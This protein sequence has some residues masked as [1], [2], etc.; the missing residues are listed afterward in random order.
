MSEV[1]SRDELLD[2][3]I[4]MGFA[5]NDCLAAIVACGLD[6]DKAISW[7]VDQPPK[8]RSTVHAP[9]EVKKVAV[10]APQPLVQP[11]VS[12][13]PAAFEDP[14]AKAQKEKDR[15]EQERRIN[16]DWNANKAPTSAVDAKKPDAE[17]QI[18]QRN[19]QQHQIQSVF[20][21]T[22]PVVVPSSQAQ[23]TANA[24]T[25]QT[26]PALAP[27]VQDINFPIPLLTPEN[28]PGLDFNPRHIGGSI[29]EP[30]LH[31]SQANAN[32]LMMGLP[33]LPIQQ[34]TPPVAVRGTSGP[35]RTRTAGVAPSPSDLFSTQQKPVPPAPGLF[36]PHASTSGII[37]PSGLRRDSSHGLSGEFSSSDSLSSPSKGNQYVDGAVHLSAVARPFVPKFSTSPAAPAPLSSSMAPEP[38]SLPLLPTLADPIDNIGWDPMKIVNDPVLPS[39]FL[40]STLG[41]GL[42]GSG[43]GSGGL[44]S[45]WQAPP[46]FGLFGSGTGGSE[47]ADIDMGINI[48]LNMLGLDMDSDLGGLGRSDKIGGTSLLERIGG[49]SSGLGGFNNP[50][51][52]RFLSSLSNDPGYVGS[53][54][55]PLGH[56]SGSGL[57]DSSYFANSK[58]PPFPPENK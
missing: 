43:L 2:H 50:P 18:K 38:A 17:K 15:K 10:P 4:A 21:A 47:S 14:Q 19:H 25:V 24:P 34:T 48:P 32:M 3:L 58:K 44:G 22:V 11:Q 26:S 33:T 29:Y 39:S 37:G 31:G 53:S 6:V 5:E 20:N 52:S 45:S 56:F 13:Q 27:G 41:S 30:S 7:L 9:A 55:D 8:P 23:R 40:S 54:S 49:G 28:P 51:P 46:G 35:A 16:R 57:L 1:Q 12:S 36:D 42:G